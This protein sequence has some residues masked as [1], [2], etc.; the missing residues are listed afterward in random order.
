MFGY[1]LYNSIQSVCSQLSAAVHN[2]VEVDVLNKVCMAIRGTKWGERL[3]VWCHIAYYCML[4][5]QLHA[6]ACASQSQV[7]KGSAVKPMMHLAV[8]VSTACKQ[9]RLHEGLQSCLQLHHLP[10]PDLPL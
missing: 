9:S 4:T 5:V 10:A 7:R 8:T 3:A 2:C 1:K 6:F